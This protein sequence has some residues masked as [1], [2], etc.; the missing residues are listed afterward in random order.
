[1]RGADWQRGMRELRPER[2]FVRML[3]LERERERLAIITP[4]EQGAVAPN[5]VRL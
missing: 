5:V 3:L 2:R 1:M 4:P